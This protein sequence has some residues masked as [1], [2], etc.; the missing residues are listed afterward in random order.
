MSV[1]DAPISSSVMARP[2]FGPQAHKRAIYLLKLLLAYANEE[3]EDCD[4]IRPHIKT[5]WQTNTCLV[6][7]TKLRHLEEL[8]TFTNWDERLKKEH[9]RAALNRFADLGIF[10]DN[11]AVAKGSE[12]WRFTLTL[13]YPRFEIEKNLSEFTQ[14]WK[15]ARPSKSREVAGPIGHS[16][17]AVGQSGGGSSAKTLLLSLG[18]AP[19]VSAFYGREDELQNPEAVDRRQALSPRNGFGYGRHGQNNPLGETSPGPTSSV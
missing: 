14:V 6:V 10:T 9:I 18:D 2:T 1:T 16:G 4:R 15:A 13:W 11:R 7:D 17:I 8:S 3:I 19:D 12:N 5:H